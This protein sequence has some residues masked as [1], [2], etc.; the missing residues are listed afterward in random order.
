[1]GKVCCSQSKHQHFLFQCWCILVIHLKEINLKNKNKVWGSDRTLHLHGLLLP[2][3]CGFQWNVML[4]LVQP[5]L[6]LWNCRKTF[7]EALTCYL[8][9]HVKHIFFSTR[10]QSWWWHC[11]DASGVQVMCAHCHISETQ[12]CQRRA[13]HTFTLSLSLWWKLSGVSVKLNPA[14][15]CPLLDKL[16]TLTN[17]RMSHVQPV[18]PLQVFKRIVGENPQSLFFFIAVTKDLFSLLLLVIW[19]TFIWTI[20]PEGALPAQSNQ[21]HPFI[22]NNY[23][24]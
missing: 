17:P 5:A 21:T 13:A 24:Q 1:M 18:W 23:N 19:E 11:D 3:L 8:E 10:F 22:T 12:L 16:R 20:A 2:S 6:F 15:C 9:F 4:V 14:L 7:G